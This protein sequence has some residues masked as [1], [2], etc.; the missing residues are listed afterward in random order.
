MTVSDKPW[1]S[2]SSSRYTIEQW[3]HAC[4]IDRRVGDPTSKG[5]YSLPVRDPDGRVNRNGLSA[6]AGRLNQVKGITT[7]QRASVA[8]QLIQ[9]YGE[10]G[11]EP[12]DHLRQMANRSAS[13]GVPGPV[14]R[15]GWPAA[16]SG[17]GL[18][19]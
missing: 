3:Q 14:H 4:L 17:I 19:G 6:A 16:V 8:R 18:E 11:M 7:D 5:R 1:D 9:L 13:A 2:S 15:P 10:A 12:P